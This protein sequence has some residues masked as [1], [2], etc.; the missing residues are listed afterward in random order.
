LDKK[1]NFHAQAEY[2]ASKATKAFSKINRFIGG[3]QW[4]MPATGTT[5][6]K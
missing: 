1:L 2:A 3:R 5:L 6:H 4:L